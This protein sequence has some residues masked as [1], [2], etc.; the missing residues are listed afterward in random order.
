MII[1]R[2]WKVLIRFLRGV[3][4]AGV[5]WNRVFDL[6]EVVGRQGPQRMAAEN[7]TLYKG[8]GIALEDIAVAAQVYFQAIERGFGLELPLLS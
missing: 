3:P 4:A 8:L 6:S 5:D 7:I 2:F 1:P